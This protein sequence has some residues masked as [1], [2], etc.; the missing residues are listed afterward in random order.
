M[1]TEHVRSTARKLDAAAEQIYLEIDRV[2][3]QG[4]SIPWQSPR[5]D[6]YV[7]SLEELCK[8]IQRHA[9]QGA[10]LSQRLQREVDKWIAVNERGAN[11]FKKIKRSLAD[12]SLIISESSGVILASAQVLGASTLINAQYSQEYRDMSWKA[13]FAEQG[14]LLGQIDAAQMRISGMR[15]TE[16]IQNDINDI[17]AQ[18]ADLERKKNEAQAKAGIWYNNLIPDWPLERDS[19]GVPWRVI[20][21]DFEDEVAKY[22][23]QIQG[24]QSRRQALLDELNLRQQTENNL[25]DLYTRQDALNQVINEGI[26]ADGPTKP[27]WLH[28]QLAGCTYYVAH[29][30]DVSDFGGGHP[31]D[32]KVWDNQARAAGYEVG[33]QPAK[34]AIM[35]FERNNNVMPKVS[36]AGHVAYVENVERVDG[37][38]KV[39]ISQANTQYKDKNK[40]DFERGVYIGENISNV[41]VKDDSKGISFIYEKPN[42]S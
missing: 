34:G 12:Q 29:K 18:L 2:A 25:A 31:G 37:G 1:E 27:A 32:A 6:R 21:D 41:I 14:N 36:D 15:T 33:R 24:L 8:K 7:A 11:R 39:T 13:R 28:K 42:K 17:D 35:V 3:R 16:E 5:R 20:A 4:R 22:D 23:Q 30:R 10:E 19:D 38:Y 26:P 9:Q 40:K